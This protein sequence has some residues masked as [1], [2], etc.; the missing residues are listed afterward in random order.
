MTRQFR[1][2]QC[3]QCQ[4]Y[5]CFP[6]DVRNHKCPR[7]NTQL[8]FET[9]ENTYA[10]S[11][12][13]AQQAVETRQYALHNMHPPAAMAKTTTPTSEVLR[14]LRQRRGCTPHWV[15]IV[16][17]VAHCAKLGMSSQHVKAAVAAL[18]DEGFLELREGSVRVISIS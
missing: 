13:E 12:T 4:E 11:A 1:V 3:P 15:A 9:L 5:T 17:V 7:C 8:E 2:V 18:I 14:L 16:D 10:G 6:V